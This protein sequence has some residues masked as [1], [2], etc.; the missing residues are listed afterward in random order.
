M[1]KPEVTLKQ[2]TL[3][4]M[5]QFIR[6][7][8][9]S[10]IPEEYPI[11][12]E[13][14]K[15]SSEENIRSGIL[16]FRD[17]LSFILDC[18]ADSG[19]LYEKPA[20][21]TQNDVSHTSLAVNY[22]FLNNVKSILINIGYH[23]E[24]TNNGNSIMLNSWEPLTYAISAEGGQFKAR[25]SAPKV[26]EALRF[27]SSCGIFVNGICLEAEKPELTKVELL[28]VT[29]PDNPLMLTGL[30][31]MAVA[32]M[33]LYTKGNHESFLRCDYSAIMDEAAEAAFM[34]KSFIKPL[35]VKLQDFVLK[36]HQRYIKAGMSC[37]INVFYLN[38]R[39]IYSFKNKEIWTL[40]A[41]LNSGYRILIKAQNT[42]KY[43]DIIKKFPIPLQEKIAMGYGCEKKRF[44]THC[45]KGC[46]GF[47]FPLDDSMLDI[48]RDIETW[49]DIELS[50]Y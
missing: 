22:P 4:D 1:N 41:S 2:K 7:F 29:Y 14:R 17:F 50:C 10:D 37:K 40:S 49:L 3:G 36:L 32:Q 38:I 42:H 18:L 19:S 25:I 48:S 43:I 30:K 47:S 6:N 11:K 44:G 12:A 21:N 5:A 27:L 24:L 23:G 35:P 31:A 13:I 15:I 39:L 34:L 26:I 20:K 45:Q 28:E 8:I 46:H 16:A 9:P 33:E